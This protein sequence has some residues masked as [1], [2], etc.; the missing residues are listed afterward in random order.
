MG[1]TQGGT[2]LLCGG[3]RPRLPSLSDASPFL[4]V[5]LAYARP[6]QLHLASLRIRD[7]VTPRTGSQIR[8][9]PAPTHLKAPLSQS[10][11]PRARASPRHHHSPV[12]RAGPSALPL[13]RFVPCVGPHPL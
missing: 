2:A 9:R 12:L 6:A 1:D 3:G 8:D 5:H 11:G 4:W 10:A 7:R 13:A